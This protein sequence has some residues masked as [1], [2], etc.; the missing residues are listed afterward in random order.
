V[1]EWMKYGEIKVIKYQWVE[2]N[3]IEILNG[4]IINR[5]KVEKNG[6]G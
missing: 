1:N 6:I 3:E 5:F 4:L 2:N